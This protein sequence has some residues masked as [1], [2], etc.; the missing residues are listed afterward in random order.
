MFIVLTK[1]FYDKGVKDQYLD[2]CRR[3]MEL[4]KAQP[5]LIGI[6]M[7]ISHDDTHTATYFKWEAKRNHE[8]CTANPDWSE[9]NKEFEALMRAGKIRFELNTYDVLDY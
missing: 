1:T 9:I 4:F 6:R 3:S 8:E 7:L 5:G 2:L